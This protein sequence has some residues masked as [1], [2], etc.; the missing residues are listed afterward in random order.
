MTG[1]AQTHLLLVDDEADILAALRSY[2]TGVLPS[3]KLHTAGSGPEALEVLRREPVDVLMT[4]YK[5][6]GMDGLE[7]VAQARTLRPNSARI[8][9]TAFPDMELAI[10]ALNEGR[11]QH[12]L[13]K[14]LEPDM[15]RDVLKALLNEAQARRQR[16]EALQRSL[17]QMK[18][19]AS[20]G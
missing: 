17:D 15:V 3:T 7:V 14:P 16:D 20:Q 5:M 19:R 1:A 12:F 13:T 11:I 2:L 10:R 8:M 4:D 18:R 6:P 9:M